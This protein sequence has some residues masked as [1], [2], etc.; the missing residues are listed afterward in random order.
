MFANIVA[1]LV[2]VLP[3][4]ADVAVLV[5]LSLTVNIAIVLPTVVVP[6]LMMV[7]FKPIWSAVKGLLT[8]RRCKALAHGELRTGHT[9]ESKEVPTTAST[10]VLTRP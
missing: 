3:M 7:L 6:V 1:A 9:T 10:G 8:C 2:F 5:W 4:G